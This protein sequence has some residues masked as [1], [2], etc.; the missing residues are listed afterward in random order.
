MPLVHTSFYRFTPLAQPQ[1]VGA[2]LRELVSRPAAQ[3]LAGS[4]L[5]AAE[6]I[7]GMLAG[8]AAAVDCFEQALQQDAVFDGA[9]TG[10]VFKRSA[11]TTKPFGKMK[12]QVKKEIVPLGIEGV[13]ARATGIDVSPAEWRELIRQPD[14]VL[15]DNRN[16][17]EF[18]L[19]HFEGAVDPGVTNFRDFP[20]YVRTHVA[21]WK[22][23]GKRVAMY[24]T[25]G[26]RCEKT[27]AWM[28]DMDLPVYQLEGGILNYFLQMPDAQL[29]W[30]GEC[31][32]F[33][34]RVAL[35]TALQETATTL[36]D[37]YQGE[38]D[39]EWRLR[40][41]LRLAEAVGE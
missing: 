38:Q 9:F 35:D 22:A 16:S 14:V 28:R 4:I 25:G 39:G 41:A 7:N 21:E 12:V 30:K 1:E 19:G 24:C 32:V 31:F 29:D 37:V 33:D 2:A 11:C 8:T 15:L 40:R 17:F 3:G 18:R 26:I 34:N 6:G 20:E 36:E 10:I 27:S 13:D 23:Q 5:V